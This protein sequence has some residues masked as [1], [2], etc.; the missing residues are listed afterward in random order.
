MSLTISVATTRQ[1]WLYPL[2]PGLVRDLQELGHTVHVVNDANAIRAS[3]VTFLLSYW[4]IVSTEILHRSRNNL[5]V[6]ESALP[7]GRGWS[8]VTW[9]VLE[10]KNEIP[11]CLIEATERFDSGDIYLT[12]FMLLTGN[13]LLAQIRREQ[14][15]ITF[16]LVL[17]FVSQ[18]PGIL[19]QATPQ[20]GEESVSARRG[21]ADSRL[22]PHLAIADQFNLL[23]VVD[24]DAYPAFFELNGA[25]YRLQI[26]DVSQV[27]DSR[28]PDED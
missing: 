14:A 15:R 22:D 5:V 3:D 8:P 17:D 18:Y 24:N 10:G 20:G 11:V 21:P 19:E 16:K 27:I 25:T 4:E 9:Q 2:L 12:D 28:A 6:H 1:S 7:L 13:E 23:R 26:E